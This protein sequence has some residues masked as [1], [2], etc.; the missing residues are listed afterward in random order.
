MTDHVYR[1]T[2][3]V[4][5]NV[6]AGPRQRIDD[7]QRRIDQGLKESMARLRSTPGIGAEIER[8][9]RRVKEIETR[10]RRLVAGENGVEGGEGEPNSEPA[11]RPPE[12]R[13]DR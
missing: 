3:I 9:E 1:V 8:L 13:S 5:E 12:E 11:P 10:L 2:E 7:L 6:L 4:G